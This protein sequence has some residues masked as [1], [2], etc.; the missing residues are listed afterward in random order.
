MT[1]PILLETEDLL[2]INKPSGLVVHGDGKHD[3][4]TVVDFVI[5]KYPEAAA[6]GEQMEIEPAGE[7]IQVQRSGIVHRIDRD[8]SGCLI[9]AK[10][11]EAFEFLKNQF[12]EH[13]I[14]KKYVAIVFGWPRDDRGIINQP[15]GRSAA[16]IRAWTTKRGARGTLREA[17]TRYTVQKR[18]EYNGEKYALMDLYPQTG[19]THQ[20]R[21]HCAAGLGTPILGDGKYGGAAAHLEGV[22]GALHLHARA[23]R[24]PHPEGGMLEAAA[25]LPPHM[26]ETFAHFGFAAPRTPATRRLP[27]APR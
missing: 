4:P 10:N 5:E 7:T 21:V 18:F 17:I 12:K 20:L 2:V 1:I 14:K 16:N 9:I 6:V 22:S 27:S 25:G 8:T 13:T 24:L 23:L 26:L 15:I 19:R 3:E 11:Q